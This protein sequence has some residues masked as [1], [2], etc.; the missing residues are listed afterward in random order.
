MNKRYTKSMDKNG[1]KSMNK[2]DGQNLLIRKKTLFDF[3]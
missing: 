3:L 1:Y 2:N